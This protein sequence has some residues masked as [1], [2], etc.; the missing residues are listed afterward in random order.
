MRTWN[1]VRF[2]KPQEFDSPDAPGS[3]VNMDLD[4]VF[5]LDRLREEVGY[6]LTINSGYRTPMHNAAEGGVECSAHTLGFAADIRVLESRTR[7]DV[8]RCAIMLGFRRIGIDKKFV[9]LDEDPAKPQDIL[10]LYS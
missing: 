8:V 10:W 3:G 1:D 7:I 5:R 9:H 2:F 6:A 4:F